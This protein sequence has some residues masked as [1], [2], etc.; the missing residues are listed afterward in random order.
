MRLPPPSLSVLVSLCSFG[1]KA[2]ESYTLCQYKIVDRQ[3]MT[4]TNLYMNHERR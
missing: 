2:V 4:K 1:G 3:L